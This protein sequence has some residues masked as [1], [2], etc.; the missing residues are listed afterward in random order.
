MPVTIIEASS[1]KE[2]RTALDYFERVDVCQLPEYHVAYS[3]RIKNSRPLLW[4][5]EQGGNRFA[6]PFLLT[7]VILNDEDTGYH[8]ISSIYGYA[9]PLSMS[10]DKAFL[11]KAWAV[12]DAWATEHQV[13]AEFTRFSLYADNAGFAHPRTSVEVNRPQAVTN[14]PDNKDAL[15]AILNKKTRNMI[16]KAEKSGLEARILN[17]G[18][19][20]KSFRKLYD[21]TMDRNNAPDFFAYDDRYYDLLLSLPE[22]EVVLA[23]VY[24]EGRMIAAAMALVHGRGALYHLGASEQEYNNLGAGNF[25]LFEMQKFL[26]EQGVKFI[27][28]GGGRTTAPD[29]PLFRFKQSNAGSVLNFHIGK[30]IV[31]RD[32]YQDI[33]RRWEDL[34]RQKVD[35]RRLIFYRS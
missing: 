5:Y 15:F 24:N 19:H 2:W 13:I 22:G 27:T 18:D 17:P 14:V 4:C 35:S 30:R 7:P 8:D 34:Y 11:G 25:V 6:Y 32:R 26:L 3:T 12:F 29:D 31:D 33:V 28:V 16:R 23:G 9:G 10:Q 20:I 21:E 1:T